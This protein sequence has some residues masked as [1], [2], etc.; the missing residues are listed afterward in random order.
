VYCDH[1]GSELR[2]RQQFC[3]SCGKPVVWAVGPT[4]RSR[5]ASHLPVLGIL[6]IVY[7]GLHLLGGTFV[8]AVLPRAMPWAHSARFGWGPAHFL[9]PGAFFGM[10]GG[11][12]LI[13]SVLGII[14]GWGLLERRP[15]ARTMAIVFGC[16]ALLNIPLGTALGVYTL[17]VL[18]SSD[19]GRQYREA[20]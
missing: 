14:A 13:V 4:R 9:L 19:S 8:A 6:W 15:W 3:R 7:S 10:F 11:F 1:C 16:L 18:A 2:D 17:W 20:V 12:L 5:V